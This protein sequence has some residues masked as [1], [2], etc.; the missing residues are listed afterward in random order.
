MKYVMLMRRGTIGNHYFPVI[1]PKTG[2]H[3][4]VAEAV[5]SM[6]GMSEYSPVSAGEITTGFGLSCHGYSETL[7]LSA[8]PDRDTQIIQMN[9]YG[10]GMSWD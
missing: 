4:D 6:P 2:V 9:D 8:E 5:I 7:G 1:F 10:A 3:S